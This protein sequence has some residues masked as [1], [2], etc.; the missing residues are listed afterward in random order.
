MLII[1]SCVAVELG[2]A[3]I[4]AREKALESGVNIGVI[5]VGVRYISTA[6]FNADEAVIIVTP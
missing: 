1:K 6:A 5:P 2:E 4:D 3:L